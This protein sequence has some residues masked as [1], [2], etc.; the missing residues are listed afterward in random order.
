MTHH[1]QPPHAAQSPHP[2]T[3]TLPASPF[4]LVVICLHSE[5]SNSDAYTGQAGTEMMSQAECE[6]KGGRRHCGE[7]EELT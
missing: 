5:V 3:S 2:S 1:L 6:T 7:L 4:L